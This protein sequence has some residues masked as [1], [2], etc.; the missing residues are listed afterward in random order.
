[1]VIFQQTTYLLTC[2]AAIADHFGRKLQLR[3]ENANTHF[4]FLFFAY[5]YALFGDYSQSVCFFNTQPQIDHLTVL[6]RSTTRI[7]SSLYWPLTTVESTASNSINPR[8]LVNKRQHYKS[9]KAAAK[10]KHELAD[11]AYNRMV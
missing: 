3:A 8:A 9:K 1:M 6:L 7:P 2:L 4:L 5:F 10:S 11:A